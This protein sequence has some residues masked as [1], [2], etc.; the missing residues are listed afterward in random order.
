MTYKNAPGWV[1][2]GLMLILIVI[3]PLVFAA[4]IYHILTKRHRYSANIQNFMYNMWCVDCA[5][6][7]IKEHDEE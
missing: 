3:H 5:K 4:L 7:F 6:V 1:V 2:F